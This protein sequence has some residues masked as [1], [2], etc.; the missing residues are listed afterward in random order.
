MLSVLGALLHAD[1]QHTKVHVLFQFPRAVLCSGGRAFQQAASLWDA[2]ELGKHFGL[3]SYCREG[4]P[5]SWL[6]QCV[7]SMVCLQ[8]FL[9]SSC[10]TKKQPRKGP[11][12]LRGLNAGFVVLPI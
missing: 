4:V 2:E 6:R 11:F 9:M 5:I 1:L 8:P 7:H 3:P 12:L 10:L